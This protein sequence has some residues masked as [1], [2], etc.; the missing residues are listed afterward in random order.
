MTLITTPS[1]LP[2]KP[3][4]KASCSSVTAA[5]S[6]APRPKPST[7]PP[8][9][10]GTRPPRGRMAKPAATISCPS[11]TSV[12]GASALAAKPTAGM[13]NS[14]PAARHDSKMPYPWAPWPIRSI[15]TG[16][17]TFSRFRAAF[18]LRLMI[19]R[20]ACGPLRARKRTASRMSSITFASR[21][22]SAPAGKRR[23]SAVTARE[24]SSGAA[25]RIVGAAPIAPTSAPATPR[26]SSG[27]P[28]SAACMRPLAR[29]SS[30]RGTMPGSSTMPADRSS[31]TA[32]PPTP[33]SSRSRRHRSPTS[34]SGS[35]HRSR[36][37]NA[38][39]RVPPPGC[40][41]RAA[42]TVGACTAR[43]TAT[44]GT[45]PQRT[46]ATPSASAKP[47]SPPPSTSAS[48]CR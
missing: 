20:N 38:R 8:A 12:R 37:S 4:G 29:A 30:L 14:M 47:A 46:S 6:V 31:T 5:T 9:R 48:G 42:A 32:R 43:L 1:T 21:G 35:R 27:T 15:A 25:A 19:R 10:Y 28:I 16:I 23:I 26:P 17:V 41:G 7:T 36:R 45:M 40:C 33:S 11:P 39:S 24:S 2:R 22:A 3:S 18:R 34:K 44:S 13:P